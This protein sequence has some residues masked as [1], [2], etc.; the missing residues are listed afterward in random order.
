MAEQLDTG[1]AIPDHHGRLTV[2]A[3]K[4]RNAIEAGDYDLAATLLLRN[5]K[6]NGAETVLRFT[7]VLGQLQ[8]QF[9]LHDA[10]EQMVLLARAVHAQHKERLNKQ[11]GV[12]RA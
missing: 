7:Y 8:S 1:A 9:N 4:V 6:A 11:F 3:R 12:K 2:T 10:E 5:S